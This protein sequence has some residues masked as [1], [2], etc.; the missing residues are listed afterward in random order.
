M[1]RFETNKMILHLI[2]ECVNAYPDWRFHQILQN[3]GVTTSEG[4]DMF[5]E[6]SDETLNR[7][8]EYAM[9]TFKSH[10]D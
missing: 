10:K 4:G 1:T 9:N 7:I 3:I 2:E 6:E 5:F 8:K